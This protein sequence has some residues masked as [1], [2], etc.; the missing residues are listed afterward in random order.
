MTKK[1]K[2]NNYSYPNPGDKNML[3][4]IFKKREFYYHR[5]PPRD[6]LKNYEEIETFRNKICT[7]TIELREQQ[8]IL[9][10]LISPYTP[11]NGLLVMHGTGT[12][13]TCGAVTVAEQFKDQVKK[14]NTKIF[15]LV[16]GP[17]MRESWKSELLQGL[18]NEIL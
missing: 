3:S 10:N 18:S 12:G 16:S 2:N 1:N 4:K 13:K 7:G 15:I 6:K 11:Y 8:M 5:I 17:N 9:S 14:Y